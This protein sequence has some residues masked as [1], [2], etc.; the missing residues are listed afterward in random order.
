MKQNTPDQELELLRK[1]LLRER[2][3]WDDINEKGCNDPFWTMA[4]I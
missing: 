2:A 1:K 3:I 4:A